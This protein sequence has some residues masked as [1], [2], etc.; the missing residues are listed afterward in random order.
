MD[1]GSFWTGVAVAVVG[2]LILFLLIEGP[3]SFNRRR[4]RKAAEAKEQRRREREE[5]KERTIERTKLRATSEAVVAELRANAELAKR[6]EDGSHVPE[7]ARKLELVEWKDRRNEMTILHLE[8]PQL[9]DD[10]RETYDALF[11]SK[12]DGGWPPTSAELLDLADRLE[13]ATKNA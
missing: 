4:G 2:G 13:A 12:R 5:A 8:D 7:E 9:W 6:C 11:R 3:R 10:L 1:W